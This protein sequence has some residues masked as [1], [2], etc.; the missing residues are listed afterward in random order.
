MD[1]E[2][3]QAF[4]HSVQ[5]GIEYQ[6]TSIEQQER[7]ISFNWTCLQELIFIMFKCKQ[8]RIR[9]SDFFFKFLVKHWNQVYRVPPQVMWYLSDIWLVSWESFLGFLYKFYLPS[10][11]FVIVS[12]LI[13]NVN[14]PK[15]N[16]IR[17]W[18]EDVSCC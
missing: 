3:T 14:S 18:A 12:T 11:V 15:G 10:I 6:V 4:N 1:I 13:C 5:T 17:K 2:W 9:N 7:L 16:Q 8:N